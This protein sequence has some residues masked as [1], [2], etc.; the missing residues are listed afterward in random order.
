MCY[1]TKKREIKS[2]YSGAKKGAV[3]LE[4]LSSKKNIIWDK[5]VYM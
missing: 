5:K 1:L 2:N 3:I 4:L